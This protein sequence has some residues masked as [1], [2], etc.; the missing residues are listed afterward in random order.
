MK[1]RKSEEKVQTDED[2]R[3]KEEERRLPQGT[4]RGHCQNEVSFVQSA[5]PSLPANEES[6]LSKRETLMGYGTN[7]L[8]FRT[9][10]NANIKRLPMFKD[11]NGE[12]CHSK[13]DGSD[14]PPASWLQAVVGELGEYANL[15]K[16]VERGDLTMQDARP[17]LADELAD[18]VIYLDIL[19]HQ[20][21]VDLGEAVMNKWNRTSKKV[22]APIYIDAEDWH[23][24]AEYEAPRRAL[25]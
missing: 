16:K 9:L 20:L 23:F 4:L 1:E 10:R 13:P 11:A 19:A 7:G 15:R 18:V 21:G 25:E 6:G 12:I 24:T 3:A 22:G 17:L 2:K 14:W 5:P 8:T